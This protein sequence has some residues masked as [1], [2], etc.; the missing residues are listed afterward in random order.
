MVSRQGVRLS[1][2]VHGFQS[3]LKL[4]AFLHVMSSDYASHVHGAAGFLQVESRR[5]V[6]VLVANGRMDRE[7]RLAFFQKRRPR[8]F[9]ALQ[10]CIT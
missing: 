4:V 10:L 2:T 3:D 8:K 5:V 1:A 7:P 9:A 6:L